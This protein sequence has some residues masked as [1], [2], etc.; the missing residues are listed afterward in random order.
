MIN[1][2]ELVDLNRNGLKIL[3]NPKG[4]CFGMDSVLL[5]AYAK[6][7]NGQRVADLCSGGGV[8]PILMCARY[9]NAR[10]TGVEIQS[11]LADMAVRS[12]RLNRLDDKIRIVQGDIRI[13]YGGL[14]RGAF[15]AV[16]VNPPYMRVVGDMEHT[17][18]NIARHELTCG[19][20]DVASAAAGLLKFGGKLY[21]VHKTSR[22]TDVITALR[23]HKLEPKTLRFVHPYI[24]APSKLFLLS[25]TKGASVDIITEAPLIIYKEPDRYSDEINFIYG[26]SID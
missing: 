12:V 20:G 13:D 11:G 5:A 2:E 18:R 26:N 22:L 17:E 7:Y 25:A 6:A 19:I 16:T 24:N 4:F 8:I 23:E 21:L 15:D 10:Y 3:Q 9:P 14:E 1:G